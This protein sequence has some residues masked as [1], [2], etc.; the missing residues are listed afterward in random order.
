MQP[1]D[2]VPPLITVIQ[3]QHLLKLNGQFCKNSAWWNVIQIQHLLKLNINLTNISTIII[4][5]KYNTC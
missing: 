2:F 1:Q 4:K 3:I 5:F